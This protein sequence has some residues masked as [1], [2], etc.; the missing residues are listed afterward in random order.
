MFSAMISLCSCRNASVTFQ[1]RSVVFGSH[2]TLA[3]VLTTSTRLLA[4]LSKLY[5]EQIHSESVMVIHGNLECRI[6]QLQSV[7]A[8]HPG[9]ALRVHDEPEDFA[10]QFSDWA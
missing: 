7:F 1:H 4:Q 5:K 10:Q 8:F 2:C 9:Q 6:D 3:G